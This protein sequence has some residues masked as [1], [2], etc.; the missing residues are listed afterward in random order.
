MTTGRPADGETKT[1]PQ[2]HGTM[3]FNSQSYIG[4]HPVGKDLKTPPPKK[5]SAW[6]C[7]ECG[8]FELVK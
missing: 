5:E 2:C 6:Q 8:R 1:C 4:V 7:G 3:V